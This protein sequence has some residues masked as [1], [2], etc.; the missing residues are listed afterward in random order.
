[1]A[2]FLVPM[3]QADSLIH[4]VDEFDVSV[5]ECHA[6]YQLVDWAD[7]IARRPAQACV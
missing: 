3:R 1:M 7:D 2:M 5:K 6:T 4:E